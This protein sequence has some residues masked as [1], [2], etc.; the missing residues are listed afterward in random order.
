MCGWTY[1]PWFASEFCDIFAVTV[2]TT[3]LKANELWIVRTNTIVICICV[4]TF[5]WPPFTHSVSCWMS[6]KPRVVICSSS[7]SPYKCGTHVF[8]KRNSSSVRFFGMLNQNSGRSLFLPY[9]MTD[10]GSG[11]DLPTGRPIRNRKY[12]GGS[13]QAR[14]GR[15]INSITM[16]KYKYKFFSNF[17]YTETIQMLWKIIIKRFRV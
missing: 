3:V 4:L 10:V 1:L 16:K 9:D 11:I 14:A 8:M 5:D 13:W 6:S 15:G 17:L 12:S 7:S 2:Y